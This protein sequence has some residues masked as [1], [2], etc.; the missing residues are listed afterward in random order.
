MS[1]LLE[2]GIYKAERKDNVFSTGLPH[3]PYVGLRTDSE[4]YIE[5]PYN[6]N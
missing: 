6:I 4:W 3:E 1:D 5:K 2:P